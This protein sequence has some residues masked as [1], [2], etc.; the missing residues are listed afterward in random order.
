MSSNKLG[1][2]SLI[3]KPER[4]LA[5]SAAA[6]VFYLLVVACSGPAERVDPK[7]VIRLSEGMAQSDFAFTSDGR[8]LISWHGSPTD[9]TTRVWN[10]SS[11]SR[12]QS[13]ITHAYY[14][15][16]S[17]DGRWI[18]A[19]S[20]GNW[21]KVFDALEGAVRCSMP[22]YPELSSNGHWV[23]WIERGE[24]YDF[25]SKRGLSPWPLSRNFNG[26]ALLGLS[27][28]HV[29]HDRRGTLPIFLSDVKAQRGFAARSQLPGSSF[30]LRRSVD[31]DDSRQLTANS[32]WHEKTTP[33]G[34]FGTVSR[35][36]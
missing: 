5:A 28:G 36:P 21:K 33:A 15:E 30:Q 8:Y 34:F 10:L 31:D 9:E 26:Y 32:L 13:W 3:P 18:M 7:Q 2:V 17:A 19:G 11:M 22:T 27:S 35:E 14:Q 4:V 6:W 25:D 20:L 23:A 16:H 29:V 24:Y 1:S 12:E